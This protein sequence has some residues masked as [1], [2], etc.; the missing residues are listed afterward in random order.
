MLDSTH[1]AAHRDQCSLVVRFVHIDWDWETRK[2]QV[3]ESFLGF[4][5]MN[6]HDAESTTNLIFN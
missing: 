4:N 5:Q 2:V 3:K 6:G 1:D